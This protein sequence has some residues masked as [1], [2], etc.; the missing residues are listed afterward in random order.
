MDT[1]IVTP[2]VL[3]AVNEDFVLIPRESVFG[4]KRSGRNSNANILP[5]GVTAEAYNIKVADLKQPVAT[6]MALVG[7]A[8]LHAYNN[9]AASAVGKLRDNAKD[10]GESFDFAKAL[11]EFRTDWRTRCIAGFIRKRVSEGLPEVSRLDFFARQIAFD[12]LVDWAKNKK[13]E[14]FPT[15]LTAAA[16]GKMFTGPGG[17]E[18]PVSDLIAMVLDRDKSPRAD[19]FYVAAQGMVDAE[20]AAKAVQGTKAEDGEED[21]FAMDEDADESEDADDDAEGDDE[22]AEDEPAPIVATPR[23]GRRTA[24]AAK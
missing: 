20:A 8:A 4:W 13:M 16:L 3:D 6:L 7:R 22:D 11:H 18:M 19:K 14:N 24:Q 9:Q 21:F 12:Y 5:E 1:T 10:K 2:D 23:N 17:K 15:R